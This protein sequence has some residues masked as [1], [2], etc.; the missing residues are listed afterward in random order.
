MEMKHWMGRACVLLILSAALRLAAQ[1][2]AQVQVDDKAQI[3]AQIRAQESSKQGAQQTTEPTLKENPLETLRKFEPAPDEEYQ[4][5]KGDEITVNFAGRPEM[6]AK[7]VVGPDGR[8]TLPL[9][10][11]I[12]LAELTRPQAGAAIES[13]LATYYTNLSVQVT[14]TKYTA[15]RVLL[16]GAVDHPGTFEFDGTPTLLEVM[17]RGGV[18]AGPNKSGTTPDVNQ[19]P[20]RCAIYRGSD[21]VV[22]V[23]LRQMMETGNALADLRL[24][25]DDV[26]YVPSSSE[27]F[28]S[29]LGEVQHPG[30]IPLAYNSTLA[31]VLAQAGGVNDHAGNNPHVQIVDPASGSSRVFS[32]KDLL[33]PVKSREVTL[34]PGE[35]I[36][37]PKS[38]FYRATYVLERLSPLVTL[39][40]MA[41]YAGVL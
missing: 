7:L 33:D 39:A 8:I 38:G 40:T 10:G 21:Q 5:G 25:R 9:A 29:V 6:Q 36:F 12:M 13:A 41:M 37:V 32:L 11:D 28:I 1:D 20:E 2:P 4:L 30:A 31:S 3:E 26:V 18:E 35:I 23:E 34:K 27:R 22:W 15:N 19:I 14:V 24:R 16:L 17:A